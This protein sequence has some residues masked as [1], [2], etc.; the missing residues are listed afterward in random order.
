MATRGFEP[1]VS[2]GIQVHTQLVQQRARALGALQRMQRAGAPRADIACQRRL[3]AAYD[4]VLAEQGVDAGYDREHAI[5]SRPRRRDF[6]RGAYRRDVLTIL[7]VAQRPM[8]IAEILRDL[9][10]MHG[11]LPDA[12]QRRHAGAKL[13]EGV[14][15]LVQRKLVTRVGKSADYPSATCSYALPEFAGSAPH[16]SQ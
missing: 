15:H 16:V 13:A 2:M 8:R 3:I 7:S 10:V 11:A 6:P 1:R 14:W 5:D 9:C 12:A 4:L